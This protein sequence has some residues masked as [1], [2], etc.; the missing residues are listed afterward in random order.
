MYDK[1]K[2]TEIKKEAD[3]KTGSELLEDLSDEELEW[4]RILA[5][6]RADSLLE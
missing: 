3:P 1:P 5:H 6:E 4:L 2:N